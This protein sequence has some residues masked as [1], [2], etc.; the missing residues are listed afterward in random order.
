MAQVDAAQGQLPDAGVQKALGLNHDVVRVAAD[1][2]A[3][4]GGDDAVG[5]A[6]GAAVL[7]L[8]HG[9][10]AVVIGN[11]QGRERSGLLGPMPQIRLALLGD[12]LVH[13]V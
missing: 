9:P 4:G 10:G 13:G 5:A 7:D 12:D 11:A 1:G 6:V 8:D 3:P 2:A